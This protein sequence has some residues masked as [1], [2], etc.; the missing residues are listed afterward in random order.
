MDTKKIGRQTVRFS[1]PPS[2]AGYGSA[3]GQ[4]EREGPLG[5][6]FDFAGQDDT[7]GEKS[8]EKAETALQ[9]KALNFAL[10]KAGLQAGDLVY[11]V[12]DVK[13]TSD[14]QLVK[15]IQSYQIGDTV[16]FTVIRENEP[17]KIKVKLQ[18]A[19][20]ITSKDN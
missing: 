2:I 4:M 9:K 20:E 8:W 14:S 3:V 15:T 6:Y 16:E 10:E 7:F 19:H 1:S 11:Y 12:D 13:I 18:A 5:Q 17:I